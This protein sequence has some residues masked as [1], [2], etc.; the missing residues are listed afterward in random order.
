MTLTQSFIS[1]S[2]PAEE[3]TG[4]L[5]TP[6]LVLD[7]VNRRQGKIVAELIKRQTIADQKE[8]L[9]APSLVRA[10]CRNHQGEMV[11]QAIKAQPNL[12]DQRAILLADCAAWGLAAFGQ[13]KALM[14][15]VSAQPISAQKQILSTSCTQL[16][17]KERGFNVSLIRIKSGW[18]K[19]TRLFAV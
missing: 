9:C 8:I 14:A 7:L 18:S 16:E 11:V 12:I 13:G 10:L 6:S 15:F 1:A 4:L 3:V 5:K 19:S 17:L 2:L